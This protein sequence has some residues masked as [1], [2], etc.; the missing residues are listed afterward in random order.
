MNTKSSIYKNILPINNNNRNWMWQL[1][2]LK[3]IF[4]F[5]IQRCTQTIYTISSKAL[6]STSWYFWIYEHTNK[7]VHC[8]NPEITK[9]IMKL[10]SFL[11]KDSANYFFPTI[12]KQNW[13]YCVNI[14][15][16]IILSQPNNN[17]NLTQLQLELG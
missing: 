4:C 3:I 12:Q 7:R 8:P 6:F 11:T 1:C 2:T 16:L 9:P 17:L 5:E 15:W 14:F 10:K 13:T